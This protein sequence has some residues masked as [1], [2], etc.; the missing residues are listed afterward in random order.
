[1]FLYSLIFHLFEFDWNSELQLSLPHYSCRLSL[2]FELFHCTFKEEKK[3]KKK[4]KTF[5]GSYAERVLPCPS[6]FHPE[7]HQTDSKSKETERGERAESKVPVEAITP[8]RST[9]MIHRKAIQ[10]TL[11]CTFP[12]ISPLALTLKGKDCSATVWANLNLHHFK[13]TV[14]GK[15]IPFCVSQKIHV[16]V[17]KYSLYSWTVFKCIFKAIEFSRRAA[18]TERLNTANLCGIGDKWGLIWKSCL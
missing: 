11:S 7:H 14:Y 12:W 13:C 10:P 3:K 16:N 15:Q 8:T 5:R 17:K 9:Q 18:M 4:K 2:R 6:R 1:M